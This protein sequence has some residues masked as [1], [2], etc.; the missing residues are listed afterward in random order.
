MRALDPAA[1][2]GAWERG[3]GQPP[4]DRALALLAAGLPETRV[5]E[6][7]ELSIGRRDARL[8]ALRELTFGQEVT[9]VVACPN[10]SERL[11][12]TFPLGDVRVTA[13]EEQPERLSLTA[14]GFEVQVRLPNSHDLAA[15]ARAPDGEAARATLLRRCLLLARRDGVAAGP[16]KLPPGVAEAIARA[17][18][19]ADPQ[20]N[21]QLI[22]SCPACLQR[23]TADFDIGAFF[24]TE[25]DAEAERLL[26]DVAALARAYG[27]READVLALSPRRRQLYLELAGG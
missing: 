15:A 24:W 18:E 16:E 13:D 7:A 20:A 5:D 17:M 3:L 19:A 8:M 1:L 10:C 22:L 11:E 25:V 21:V 26:R 23:G 4:A 9:A 2:L 6:L 12:L 14:E 27:W